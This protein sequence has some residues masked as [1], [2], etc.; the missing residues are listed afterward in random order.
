M[1]IFSAL[2]I[3]S[4]L[5]NSLGFILKNWKEMLLG[6]ALAMVVYQNASDTE[7]LKWV[8]FRTIPAIEQELDN[9]R[10]QLQ[11]CEESR[12]E[13]KGQIASTNQQID[14]WADVSEKLQGVIEK[15]EQ[16]LNQMKRDNEEAVQ[17]I[18]DGPT[19]KTCEAAIQYLRDAAGEFEW[20]K[21]QQ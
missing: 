8:G 14:K 3:K 12:A 21:S 20:S 15:Q 6:G 10:Q 19:P 9:T 16:Q 1:A 13:L 17:Q 7:W 5:S 4:A 2:A 11:T 18:L